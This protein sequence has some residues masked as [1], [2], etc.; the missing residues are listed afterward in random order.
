MAYRVMKRYEGVGGGQIYGKN[1]LC[2]TS[3]APYTMH[4]PFG[5]T[6]LKNS[7]ER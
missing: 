6:C 1:A 4:Y 5:P 7:G 2:N 3:M